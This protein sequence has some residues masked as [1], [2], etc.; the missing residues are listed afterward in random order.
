M[1]KYNYIFLK[2]G[3]KHCQN[4]NVLSGHSYFH[5]ILQ[6]SSMLFMLQKYLYSYILKMHH[7]L[8]QFNVGNTIYEKKG[9]DIAIINSKVTL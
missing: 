1:T 4:K 6:D 9:T 8:R 3:K 5:A 2:Q 7:W